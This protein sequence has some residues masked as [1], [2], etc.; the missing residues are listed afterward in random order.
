MREHCPFLFLNELGMR[1]ADY[2]KKQIKPRLDKIKRYNYNMVGL[3]HQHAPNSNSREE[4]KQLWSVGMGH[5]H[6]PTQAE[7]QHRTHA[8]PPPKHP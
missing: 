2:I 6:N 4:K 1:D 5:R 8:R 7:A 3:G